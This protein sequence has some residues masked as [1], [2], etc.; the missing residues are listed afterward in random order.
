MLK[1]VFA[2]QVYTCVYFVAGR[3]V[4]TT[5]RCNV[6]QSIFYPNAF[7]SPTT[8]NTMYADMKLSQ[9]HP[10]CCSQN[11]ARRFH[12]VDQ[13]PTVTFQ[14][15]FFDDVCVL[16]YSTVSGGVLSE[17]AF[18]YGTKAMKRRVQTAARQKKRGDRPTKETIWSF[19]R[20]LDDIAKH[21][22]L[23]HGSSFRLLLFCLR[24]SKDCFLGGRV[25]PGAVRLL[26]SSPCL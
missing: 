7:L 2:T 12:P 18:I 20:E 6:V 26:S 13:N 19:R 24:D 25:R 3:V 15:L 23:V 14:P 9:K 5:C 1:N 11:L 16:R 22:S 17:T 21:Q 10:A 4:A 8:K